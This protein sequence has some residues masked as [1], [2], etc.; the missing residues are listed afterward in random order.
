VLAIKVL[1]ADDSVTMQ[2]VMQLSLEHE[3]F[4][5]KVTGDGATAYAMAIKEKPDLIIADV[6][7][8]GLNGFELC[9]KIK[10]NFATTGIPVVLISGEMEE[11][12]EQKGSEAGALAHIT[13]PF[14][15]GEFISTIKKLL[16]DKKEA[17]ESLD[18]LGPEKL[19]MLELS[20]PVDEETAESVDSGEDE[21]LEIVA[22]EAESAEDEDDDVDDLDLKLDDELMEI[23][24]SILNVKGDAKPAINPDD[25]E[26]PESADEL[27]NS[28]LRELNTE[29]DYV[30]APLRTVGDDE[31]PKFSMSPKSNA[32]IQTHVPDAEFRDAA[33]QAIYDFLDSNAAE[34]FREEMSKAIETRVKDIFET[35]LESAF[36]EEISKIISESFDKA[37]PKMLRL[38]ENVTMEITPKIAEQMIKTAIDQIKGGEI[39]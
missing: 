37:M 23:E 1:F 9:K 30:A 21:E 13:K 32:P 16:G 29:A 22:D 10:E 27:W 14:K 33:R 7:M 18:S 4:D 5:L 28:T 31:I 8:P 36:R 2:K 15:S 35:R 19:A 3:G 39:N 38:I 6:F 34:I 24:N 26:S 17:I 20:T 25:L 11:Y 12:D